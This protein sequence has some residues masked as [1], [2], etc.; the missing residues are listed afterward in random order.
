MIPKCIDLPETP[1]R[2][3]AYKQGHSMP[4]YILIVPESFSI[5]RGF[6]IETSR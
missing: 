1:S 4:D 3:F 6:G 2:I 5:A